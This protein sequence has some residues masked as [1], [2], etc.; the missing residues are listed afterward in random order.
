MHKMPSIDINWH[1]AMKPSKRKALYK[2][3]VIDAMVDQVDTLFPNSASCL[4]LVSAIRVRGTHRRG[5]VCA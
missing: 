1:I 4:R 3:N 5:R 2:D